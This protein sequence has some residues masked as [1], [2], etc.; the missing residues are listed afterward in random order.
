MTDKEL[1]EKTTEAHQSL[2]EDFPFMENA[3]LSVPLGWIPIV[4]D[5]CEKI[6]QLDI[7]IQ[8]VQVKEKFAG[9]RFYYDTD[10][11]RDR[12]DEIVSAAEEKVRDACEICGESAEVRTVNNWQHRYCDTHYEQHS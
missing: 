4:R 3:M 7:E 11:Q 1:F 2:R 10:S 8:V 6:S 9:L 12:I 5:L